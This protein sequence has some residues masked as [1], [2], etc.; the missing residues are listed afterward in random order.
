MTQLIALRVVN[1]LF[2][3]PA[4]RC[5]NKKTSLK[6]FPNSAGEGIG[7]LI[8][9]DMGVDDDRQCGM[10][11][12][13]NWNDRPLIRHSTLVSFIDR[14]TPTAKYKSIIRQDRG[15]NFQKRKGA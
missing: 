5:G 4:G 12:G 8:R 1:L 6:G 3:A 10:K 11:T 15:R 9:G 13:R 2:V 14:I 7:R